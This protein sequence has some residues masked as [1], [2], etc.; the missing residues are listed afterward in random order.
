MNTSPQLDEVQY[1]GISSF[2]S[3]LVSFATNIQAEAF[4]LYGQRMKAYLELPSNLVECRTPVDLVGVQMRFLAILQRNYAEA[5]ERLLD[6]AA[7]EQA[8]EPVEQD[9]V[10]AITRRAA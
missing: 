7:S 8:P 5:T 4:R 10:T 9:E 6:T 3:P 1:P 2:Q